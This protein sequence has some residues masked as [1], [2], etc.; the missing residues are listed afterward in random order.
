[1]KTRHNLPSWLAVLTTLVLLA[2]S[3]FLVRASTIVTEEPGN[4][5]VSDPTADLVL[6]KCDPLFPDRPCSLAPSVSGPPFVYLPY[7]DITE[8]NITAQQLGN[9]L[10]DMVISLNGAVPGTLTNPA[11]STTPPPPFLAYFWQ[12]EN[13]CIGNQ[14]GPTD[15]DGA[16]VVWH[17]DTQTFTANWFTIT[18][19][20]PRTI[21]QDVPL[22]VNISSDGKQL[23]VT[24]DICDL[25]SRGGDPLSWFAGVRRIGFINPT[26]SK[27]FPMEVAPDVIALNPNP[28]P[29]LSQPE[30]P[31]QWHGACLGIDIKPHS[32]PNS[33]NTKKDGRIPVA[34]LSSST[35]DAPSRVDQTS[36]TFGPT[37]NEDSLD[38]CAGA[39][40]V[41]GDGFLDLVCHFNTQATGFQ[42]GDT[43][44]I[45]KGLTVDPIP[46]FLLGR[47]S[48]R[49]VQ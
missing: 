9:G 11:S 44:G 38:F 3:P 48:V 46:A 17:F 31:A 20:N 12:F 40:D 23:K 39:E 19:C 33:I 37:G 8:A 2:L 18:N 4:T 22:P 42:K 26:F 41:N 27:T 24:V 43:Q 10:V 25:V 14:P 6:K 21:Q 13:G 5:V 36:L 49:I 45:L 47:D 16:R 7:T 29:I 34:I 15:K 28:P 1:M 32:F 30:V 35:F